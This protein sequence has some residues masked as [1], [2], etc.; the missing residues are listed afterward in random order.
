MATAEELLAGGVAPNE[1]S[2]RSN[3]LVIDN[4]LRTISIQPESRVIG[5][6]SDEDVNRLYFSMPRMYDDTDL[7][8]FNAYINYM[9][10]NAD[11]DVY[12]VTDLQPTEDEITFSWLIGRHATEYKGEVKF[13]VCL[14]RSENGEVVQEF[15]T[16]VH[17]L[18]V[19]EGLEIELAEEEEG[20][21]RDVLAQLLSLIEAQKDEAIESIKT[22][23]ASQLAA[24]STSGAAQLS[25]IENKG[26]NTLATIP[27][28]YI[29]LSTDVS[30]LKDH[31]A[32]YD[33]KF[34]FIRPIGVLRIGNIRVSN[35]N[36]DTS[37]KTTVYDTV[38]IDASLP[39]KITIPEGM[40]MSLRF[41][42]ADGTYNSS[43]DW[44]TDSEEAVAAI[45]DSGCPMFCRVIGYAEPREIDDITPF[46]GT[47]TISAWDDP[48]MFFYPATLSARY[49]GYSTTVPIR[50]KAGEKIKYSVW[51]QGPSV[52][53]LYLV[54][55][56]GS[57]IDEL[58]GRSGVNKLEGVYTAPQDGFV[59][60]LCMNKNHGS[61]TEESYIV[62]NPEESDAKIDFE[63]DTAAN[64][65]MSILCAKEHRYNDGTPMNVEWYLLCDPLTNRLYL[66]KDMRNKKYAFT[67]EGNITVYKFAVR[68]N[69]DIIAV[70]RHEF[71]SVTSEYGAALD[72]VR[73][74]PYVYLASEQYS[75][76]HEVDFG[77]FDAE[78][79]AGLKPCAWLENVGV[80]SMPN[81]DLMFVEYTR[82][83]VL[84]SANC[85]RI[86][87]A[88]DITKAESWEVVKS[89]YVASGD[90]VDLDDTYIEHIHAIQYDHIGDVCYIATGDLGKKSQV[91]Y[92]K[93]GGDTWER[94][95]FVD[96]NTGNTLTYGQKLFRLLNYNFTDD[97]VYWSS[98]SSAEHGIMRCTR[99]ENGVMNPSGIEVL[100]TLANLPGS[101]ATYGSVF[102]PEYNLMVLMERCDETATEMKFRAYDVDARE[103]K[104]IMTLKS[105]TG[106]A[107]NIGFR[108]EYTEFEPSDGVIRCGF[109]GNTKL[110]NKN[111][112]CGNATLTDWKKGVNNL[113]IRVYV[114][115]NNKVRA[116][117]GTYYL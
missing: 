115:K 15:N 47:I 50:F 83:G 86:K 42:N 68:S 100:D 105:A 8:L 76:A 3:L 104:E 45:R 51:M 26:K 97:Y 66:S 19:L 41:W 22:E 21:V 36:V 64:A 18:T 11:G 16:T 103:V 46:N 69:G 78:T 52:A 65:S 71:D 114:D 53:Y 57:T 113:W 112:V 1:V 96:P 27:E 37:T 9:N 59:Y 67:F 102:Y 6:E 7:S 43:T 33:E 31:I 110:V 88:A 28:D 109:G 56:D 81:G 111:A 29:A 55:D 12:I 90:N 70:Y 13:V 34:R 95:T 80:C 61:Y 108:T 91:W 82:M 40:R 116:K 92:S 48:N 2:D 98:D 63:T 93:D 14:K 99:L 117:F 79:G 87:A 54:G 85:W 39:L 10:A 17:K 74:N 32:D 77:E 30:T 73:K 24:I 101:P 75:V 62:V 89:F 94:Q 25:A 44:I 5:V 4:D 106:A 35:G 20:K 58:Y 60:A 84:Y 72:G 49:T 38:R 23:G 107:T